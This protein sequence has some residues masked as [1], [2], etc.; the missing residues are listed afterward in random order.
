MT[1]LKL[2]P[3]RRH[4]AATVTI[5]LA[6]GFI[7]LVVLTVSLLDTAVRAQIDDDL[8]GIDTVVAPAEGNE[9][10]APQTIKPD[11]LSKVSGVDQAFYAPE[12]T[13]TMLVDKDASVPEG[14]P[15]SEGTFTSITVPRPGMD[16]RL[17]EG[18]VPS[19][20]NQIVIDEAVAEKNDLSIG[21]TVKAQGLDMSLTALTITGINQP[22]LWQPFSGYSQVIV[23]TESLT[24]LAGVPGPDGSKQLD[25]RVGVTAADGVSEQQLADQLSDAGYDART[26]T[27][28]RDEGHDMAL[29]SL[30][31]I[32]TMLG[33]FVIIALAT[34]TLVVAN[35]FAVTMAQRRRSFA[36]A[37]ALGATRGQ[38]M[39]AVVRDSVL[40]GAIG[41]ILG[42]VGA[43][44]VFW[45][46]LTWGRASYSKALPAI[47][48]FNAIAVALPI[49]AGLVLAITASVAPA[50]SVLKV[51][52][53]EALRPVEASQGR[54]ISRLRM[55]LATVIALL[56]AAGMAVSVYLA[57]NAQEGDEPTGP[58]LFAQC[59]TLMPSVSAGE[60]L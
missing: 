44:G 56:G 45:A 51:K 60:P 5:A 43:Y 36:L 21:D 53:L 33:A 29:A 13:F 25:S 1:K 20:K 6:T 48:D 49:I 10:A 19:G 27:E 15:A 28:V 52:P 41:S 11:D 2:Q 59:A 42:V 47:P 12:F 22:P 16:A 58:M 32:S 40:V 8:T 55:I 34:S 7:A 31:G 23:D 14:A 30:V 18:S 3:R 39:G 46:L 37:R 17:I 26:A 50:L 4:L 35:S 38:A 57:V 54:G 9:G 24:A